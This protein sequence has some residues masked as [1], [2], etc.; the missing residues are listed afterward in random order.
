[1]SMCVCVCVRAR[2]RVQAT[3]S[4]RVLYFS[5]CQFHFASYNEVC[6]LIHALDFCVSIYA[7][8]AFVSKEL[9]VEKRAQ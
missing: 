7:F 8:H 4:A 3:V 1:M 2:A 9:S 5:V 6:V